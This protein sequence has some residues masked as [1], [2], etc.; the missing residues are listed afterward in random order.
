METL[1][2]RRMSVK[3]PDSLSDVNINWIS[4]NLILINL[5]I[6]NSKND[7]SSRNLNDKSDGMTGNMQ[8]LCA[9]FVNSP[10]NS[11]RVGAL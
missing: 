11:H 1:Q 8:L 4:L 5:P 10:K 7:P 2:C 6:Q 9:T 3:C